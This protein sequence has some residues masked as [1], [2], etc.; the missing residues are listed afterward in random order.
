MQT[1]IQI[2]P[3]SN[4]ACAHVIDLVL[5]IQQQEFQV[6]VTLAGQP[7]LLNI[8]HSYHENGGG[9]WGAW[10]NGQL[11]GTI[12]LIAVGRQTGVIRKMFVHKDYRG[13]DRSIAQ[14][15]LN[16]L[17][18]HA[19]ASGIRHLYLGTINTMKAAMRFYER[20]GFVQIEKAALPDIFPV[21][22]VDNVFYH[23][24]LAD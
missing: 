7:D 6:P 8:E 13:K 4:E 10:H 19:R 21:M 3:V 2:T 14:Q 22:S 24:Q 1:S 15:L 9:F 12:G 23:L 20:N 18:A 5:P 16:T 11:V 17:L